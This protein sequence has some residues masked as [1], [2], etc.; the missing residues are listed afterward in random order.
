MSTGYFVINVKPTPEEL[1]AAYLTMQKL[2][3]SIPPDIGEQ[4]GHWVEAKRQIAIAADYLTEAEGD[5][6]NLAWKEMLGL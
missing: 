2:V 6:Y 1:V 4:W 3:Y 5:P